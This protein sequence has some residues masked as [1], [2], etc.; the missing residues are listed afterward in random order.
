MSTDSWL[1]VGNTMVFETPMFLV[2]WE[3]I[4]NFKKLM[5]YH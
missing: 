4:P 2:L 1:W 3:P 5:N